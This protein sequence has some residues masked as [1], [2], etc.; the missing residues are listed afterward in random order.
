M[1]AILKVFIEF[2]RASLVAQL[3]KN[4]PAMRETWLW[5][6]SWKDPLEKGKL[7][8][9]VFWL[10]KFKGLYSPWGQKESDTTEHF[11]LFLRF[12]FFFDV[13][14]FKSLFEF[15]AILLLFYVLAFWPW[16]MCDLSSPTKDQTWPPLDWKAKVLTTGPLEKSLAF[17]FKSSSKRALCISLRNWAYT[18]RKPELKKICVP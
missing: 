13:G 16:G 9:P 14:H 11:C 7:P 17:S 4:L 10:G 8:T 3:V 6:L 18:P 1:W 5:S 2:V 12:F 15:V